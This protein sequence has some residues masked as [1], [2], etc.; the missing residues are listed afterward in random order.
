MSSK[1][2]VLIAE[3]LSPATVDA[4]GPDFEIR[5][6]DGANREELL[7]AVADV[8]A[9]LVRSATRVDAEAIAA[10]RRLR[11]VARAGVGLDNVD[12]S[13]ATKAGVM[14]VNAPT[15][16]IV[17]A[18]ELACG[19]LIATARNIPQADAALR[20]GE[21]KRAKYT[22]VELSE[23]T[24]G[25]VGLGRIGV[26][27]AQRMSAFGMRVVAYDPYVQPARAAQMG[28]RLLSLDELL[29]TS[30]FITVHLPKTP[31]TIGLIGDEA[32]RRVKPTVRIVNAA[33]G[34]IVDEGA[35]YSALKEG[36][37]A[38]AGLDVYAKEPCTDSPLFQLDQVVCT[39]HLGASTDEAQEKAGI[40]VARSVRLALAGELVPDAV[41]VQGGVIAEDVKPALPLAERLG[42]IFTALA[43]EVAV[44]LDV[45]VYGEITQHDVKVLELSA[46]KG[47]FEDVVDETV[48][49]VNA[50]LFAQER[51]VEVR[52]TTSSESPD[53]RNVITV[54]GTLGG[55]EEVAVSGT[56]AG[57]RHIQKIVA[58]GAFDVDLALADH[59]VVLCYED[60]PGVVGTVGRIL[61][62]AGLNIAGM[63]VSR[64]EE[65]GEA[66][67]VLTVDD[68][69]P[70][71]VLTELADEVGAT[72][73]RSVDLT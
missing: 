61:G 66:L 62:E 25:V 71:P 1:P 64:A 70:Q 73:V 51:G 31:E 28:V 43:G 27:V 40:A 36:R 30:D 59:M 2:V 65:G 67:A 41:N 37:V 4:L 58:V 21:W 33:R 16:N 47:V 35:L 55:G 53:H 14:V 57:P 72:S 20:N 22:G 44:R 32:L 9:V 69:V 12:V 60:R 7:P 34:G 29:E 18:A 13:A 39:P 10:A 45:E 26:L 68:T 11:V 38:G 42:R 52:L 49:Y 50:P 3:E 19:L 24:L 17:T 48:S 46:L 15:S 23:K 5:H 54:R 56:L 6:C 8:D 63:Q